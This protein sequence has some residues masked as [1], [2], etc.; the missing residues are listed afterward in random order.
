[1]DGRNVLVEKT[2]RGGEYLAGLG[3][4]ITRRAAEM[5]L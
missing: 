4:M 2:T 5:A 1:M 3:D